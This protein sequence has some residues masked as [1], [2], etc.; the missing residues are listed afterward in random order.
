M[1]F[2]R[3]FASLVSLAAFV[4]LHVQLEG[5]FGSD[6]VVPLAPRL[7][8]VGFTD[9]PSLLVLTGASDGA[10]GLVALVGELASVALLVGVLPGLAA[11]VAFAAY[12]SF[13]GVGWPFV[14]LQWDTLLLEALVLTALASPWDRVL[15]RPSAL[16]EPPVMARVAIVF[17]ACRLHVASGLVKVLSGDP[18]WA[19]LDAL[20]YHF[21]TQPLPTPLAP[22]VHALPT[23]IHAA[24]TLVV[25]GLEI[26][27]PLAAPAR[28]ARPWVLAGLWLLQLTIALTGSYGFFNALSAVL[29]LP[30]LEDAPLARGAPWLARRVGVEPATEPRRGARRVGVVGALAIG[31]VTLG[32]LD[33][34]ETVGARF[35]EPIEDARAAL[36]RLHLTSPYGPF[37]VMT[38]VRRE[39][40][41]EVSPDGARWEAVRFHHKPDDV[42]ASL[43]IVP[44]HMPRMDWML[45]FAALGEPEDA[46]W[47]LLIERG[48]LEDR[49]AVRG[50]FAEVPFAGQV[51]FVRA[52]RHRYRFD[53]SGEATWVRDEREPFGPTLSRR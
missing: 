27:L 48:L 34:L 4:S 36:G 46:R 1:R 39:I 18:H 21:E 8:H 24:M 17:L 9:V 25:Y 44:L 47:V 51:R 20:D 40:S 15:V 35:P 13:V 7:E 30:L 2:R 10:M 32:A 37:G 41:I 52:V 49:A 19:A 28:V 53:P 12:L 50:L 6:G 42:A 14:P 3:A 5:L 33:F 26:V 11:L 45:W 43:P 38:T 31:L 22:L 16:S 29:A 23:S